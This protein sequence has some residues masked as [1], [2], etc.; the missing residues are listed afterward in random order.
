[1]SKEENAAVIRRGYEAFN[2]G[3]LA[4]LAQVIAE[5]AVWHPAGRGRLSGEKRGQ[6]A[7]FGYFGQLG[8]A[9]LRAELHDVIAND[10]H[11]VGL[12][13]SVAQRAGKS[14]NSHVVI[15]FH[16]RNG[17]VAEAWELADDTQKLDEYFA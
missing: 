7:I 3:D 8:E 6:E 12:H 5:D 15:V 1:M 10:D 14:L 4:T 2:R 16:L 9:G 13:T 17:R 11:A